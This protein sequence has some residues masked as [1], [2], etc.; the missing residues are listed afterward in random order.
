MGRKRHLDEE[1]VRDARPGPRVARL[2]SHLC[3][4]L[5]LDGRVTL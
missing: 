1:K 5:A 2:S 4:P 3:H